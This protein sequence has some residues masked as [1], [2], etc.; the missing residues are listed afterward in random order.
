MRG[1]TPSRRTCRAEMPSSSAARCQALC[2]RASASRGAGARC[3]PG[4]ARGRRRSP[5]PR[6]PSSPWSAARSA[7]AAACGFRCSCPSSRAESNLTAM[8][9][10]AIFDAAAVLDGGFAGR[11]DRAHPRPPSSVT[12]PA[13]GRCRPRSTS[14]RRHDG[15]F[16]AMPAR[17]DG[18]ATLKWVTSFPHNPERGLAGRGRGAAGVQRRDRRAA[19]P[20][21]DCA[22]ITSLRTGAAAAVSAQLLARADA[23]SVGADRLRRQWR[24]GGALPRRRRLRTRHLLRSARGGRRGPGGRAWLASR[25]SRTRP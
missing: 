20:S 21:C 2:A 9:E 7:A 15:D 1:P 18:L 24:V 13:I 25:D 4:N 17:G 12:P 8:G 3:R 11:R 16:R 14:R 22:A 23:G 6:S 5:P 10:V 19:W